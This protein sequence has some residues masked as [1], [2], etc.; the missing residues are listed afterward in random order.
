MRIAEFDDS[1]LALEE[2]S[3]RADQMQEKQALIALND[4]FAVLPMY[5]LEPYDTI[6]EI[7]HP[8]KT[9]LQIENESFEAA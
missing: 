5:E 3:Y 8:V 1:I 4:R 9:E 7:C 2:A 6:L